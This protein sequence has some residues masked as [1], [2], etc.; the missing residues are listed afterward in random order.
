LHGKD[1][2]ADSRFHVGPQVAL[3]SFKTG[4]V[5]VAQ[6][7]TTHVHCA[8]AGYEFVHERVSVAY[9]ISGDLIS[10]HYWYNLRQTSTGY[11]IHW[12]YMFCSCCVSAYGIMLHCRRPLMPQW[13]VGVKLATV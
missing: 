6:Q 12:A 11:A 3:L 13:F 7:L 4:S 10:Q 5:Y 8:A 9:H 2:H 1:T